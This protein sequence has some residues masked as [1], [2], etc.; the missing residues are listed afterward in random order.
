MCPNTLFINSSK[1][2][3]VSAGLG[4]HK[5]L[6]S[7]RGFIDQL[8]KASSYFP[9]HQA[10][11]FNKSKAYQILACPI[12]KSEYSSRPGFDTFTAWR[13]DNILNFLVS[14]GSPVSFQT[15]LCWVKGGESVQNLFLKQYVEKHC[16]RLQKS[17]TGIA[18]SVGWARL[19][20]DVKL[21][22]RFSP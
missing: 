4:V 19:K 12:G 2:F 15:Q 3:L 13:G 11:I 18:K 16:A 6:K 14:S 20:L 21:L 10:Y 1:T 22:Q 8:G 17:C 7:W 5:G 9:W